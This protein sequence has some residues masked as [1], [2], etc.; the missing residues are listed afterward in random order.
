[1][2]RIIVGLFCIA[3]IVAHASEPMSPVNRA[4]EQ[5]M[6]SQR[7][8]KF[9]C[10]TGMDVMPLH[11]RIQLQDSIARFEANLAALKPV[12]ATTP[13]TAQAFERLAQA[14]GPLRAAIAIPASRESALVLARHA[15]DVLAA[16]ERLT[17]SMEDA[18]GQ[19]ASRAINL[20]GRQR[21][22]S[23]RLAKAYM[24]R[25]W[26]VESAAVR[27]EMDAAA[28]EFNAALALLMGRPENT[29]PINSELH[30]LALQW[31]WLQTAVASEGAATYR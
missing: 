30:D 11:S 1:M 17:R 8:V 25:S 21:M 15:E 9:Y 27:E 3:G 13:E 5:R 20:A 7:T 6:L 18:S 28:N 26:G 19:P 29:G 23:Q 10:Q 22:L 2:F 14:W 16:A 12:A 4:G 24:L 31:E